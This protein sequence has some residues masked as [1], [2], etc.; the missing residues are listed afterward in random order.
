MS[1]DSA[2]PSLDNF[3][4]QH[5]GGRGIKGMQTIEDDY[6]EDLLMMQTHDYIMFVTD[7]GRAYRLKAYQIPEA[8]RT[9]RGTAIINLLQLNPGEKIS[10][11]IPIKAEE[12]EDSDLNLFMV[13][14]K[15]IVKKTPLSYF[16]NIRKNGIIAINIREDDELIDRKKFNG[17]LR[18]ETSCR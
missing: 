18:N 8:G 4:V 3:R 1:L 2:Y 11:V 12:A 6:I 7:M 15:G 14:K 17:C 13:T 5:R 9:A 16:D 10:A